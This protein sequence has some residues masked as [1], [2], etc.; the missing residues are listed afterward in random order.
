MKIAILGVGF[1]GSKLFDF[2]SQKYHVVGADLKPKNELIKE[3]DATNPQQVE[4]FIYKEKPT[5]VIDTIALSSYFKC[6]KNNNLCRELNFKTAKNISE[7]C[8]KYGSKMVFISSSYVFDGKKGEYEEI[9]TPNS[10]NTYAQSKIDAEKV[11]LNLKSSIVIR[12]E[13]IYGFNNETKQIVF[14]TNTFE[15][16]VQVGFPN[17]LRR[18]IFVE[19]IPPIIS[20][21]LQKN[22]SGIFNIAGHN[23]LKWYDFLI[24]LSLLEDFSEKIRIVDSSNWIL[25]PPFDTSLNIKKINLL[26]IH[27]TLFKEALKELKNNLN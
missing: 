19:D 7:S 3:L 5:I 14:G 25:K 20:I 17:L 2:F 21:L 23:K 12:L 24:E 10:T 4:N 8:S 16:D 11:V 15:N 18:P 9:D 27:P 1:L 6:E 26:G 22:L 13:P